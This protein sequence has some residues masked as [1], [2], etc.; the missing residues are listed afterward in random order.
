MSR[1]FTTTKSLMIGLILLSLVGCTTYSTQTLPRGV[2][3]PCV[4]SEASTLTL[5]IGSTNKDLVEAL[6]ASQVALRYCQGVVEVILELY[7][8]D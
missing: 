1:V 2:L 6:V 3:E 5:P 7:G 4:E 8:D